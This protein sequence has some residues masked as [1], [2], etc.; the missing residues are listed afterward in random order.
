MRGSTVYLNDDVTV[1]VLLH[2]SPSPHSPFLYYPS[3]L[4]FVNIDTVQRFYWGIYTNSFDQKPARNPQPSHHMWLTHIQDSK[5][6]I[7]ACIRSCTLEFRQMDSLQWQ[8]KSHRNCYLRQMGM[9]QLRYPS[10]SFRQMN[11]S[12]CRRHTDLNLAIQQL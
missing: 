12:M 9:D 5:A 8:I 10:T 2:A 4:A 7:S 3:Q 1:I 11:N 6:H